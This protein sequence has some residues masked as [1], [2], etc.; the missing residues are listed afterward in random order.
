MPGTAYTWSAFAVVAWP[1]SPKAHER[2]LIVPVD[3]VVKCTGS[4]GRPEVGSAVN[5]ATGG[6]GVTVI[7]PGTVCVSEPPGPVTVRL[8]AKWPVAAYTCVGF[9][10]VDVVWSP[11]V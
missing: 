4:G 3:V 7:M 9:A 11:K 1:P 10:S 2:E 5:P 6:G 8:T